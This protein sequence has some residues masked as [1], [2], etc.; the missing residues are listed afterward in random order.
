MKKI[1]IAILLLCLSNPSWSAFDLDGTDDAISVSDTTNWAGG[2]FSIS[3]WINLGA[4]VAFD[5]FVYVDDQFLLAIAGTGNEVNFN[6]E[7]DNV[8]GSCNFVFST[9]TWT[10]FVFVW[11]D[12]AKTGNCWADA[13]DQTE[14]NND[15]AIAGWTNSGGANDVFYIFNRNGSLSVTDGSVEEFYAWSGYKLVQADVDRLYSSRVRRLGCQISPDNIVHSFA[16]DSCPNGESCDGSTERNICG[17]GG[18]A[19]ASD[20]ANNTGMLGVAASNLS[21]P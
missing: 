20:G 3:F 12:T 19:T 4:N 16:F 9:G 2:D 8:D 5:R 7:P 14:D 17:S 21:Y 6:I 15:P 10:H 13:V 1:I 18:D 11:D